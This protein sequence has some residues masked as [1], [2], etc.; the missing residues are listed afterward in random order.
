MPHQQTDTKS[1]NA[2]ASAA[3]RLEHVNLVVTEIDPTAKF[4]MAAFPN[5]RVRGEGGGEWAGA[6]RRW[7]HIG[8]DDNYI[9]LNEFKIPAAAR[10]RHRDLQ[11][12]EPG[13]AHLGF[14][15]SD[16]EAVVG[17]LSA[18]GYEPHHLGETHPHRRNL[19]YVNEEGLEFEFVEYSSA[20]PAEKNLYQ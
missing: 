10:G 17:R 19:Y 9:T 8:D 16:L 3:P 5:W 6:P 1:P 20:I 11:S 7:A 2:A 4:L 18:A 14:E 15:V 13:L 12:A